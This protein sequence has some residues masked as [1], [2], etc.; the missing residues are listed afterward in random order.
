LVQMP[1]L[2]L[3]VI[4][5]IHWQAVKMWWKG[6]ALKPRPPKPAVAVTIVARD[7]AS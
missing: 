5:A 7:A 4:G 2:T 3:K 6:F 1:F